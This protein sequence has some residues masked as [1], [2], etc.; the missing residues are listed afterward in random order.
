MFVSNLCIRLFL[1]LLFSVETWRLS[2]CLGFR[3]HNSVFSL[4]LCEAWLSSILINTFRPVGRGCL[5]QRP[6]TPFLRTNTLA[7]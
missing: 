7:Q 6:R 3:A 2:S 5:P 1:L 4:F